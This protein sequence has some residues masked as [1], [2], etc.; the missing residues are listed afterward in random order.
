MQQISA[1]VYVETGIQGC[2]PGFVTTS[3][4]VVMI[5]TPHKP[6][7]AVRWRE[8][9]AARG[10]VRYIILTEHHADHVT[11]SYLF[12]GVVISQQGM[13]EVLKATEQFNREMAKSLDPQ[14]AQLLEGYYLKLPAITFNER[15]NLYLGSHTFELIHLPGHTAHQTAVYIP[16]ERVVFTGDNVFHKVQTWFHEA[17]PEGWLESLKRIEEL[18]VDVIVPG[19]GQVCDKSYLKEQASFIRE[20]M[21]AV[22]K[23]IEEG[24]SNCLLYTSP[25]PR[26]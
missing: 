19:H 2:N 26:D 14:G 13:R 22:R 9:M 18:D 4:G 1:N 24:L 23:A 5:D 10:E 20:W 3:E 12:P 21:D 25:S 16:E 17:D 7:D 8:E 11:T 6:T 15:L